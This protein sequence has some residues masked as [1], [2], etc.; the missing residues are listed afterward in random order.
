MTGNNLT[1]LAVCGD[2]FSVGHGLDPE[3]QF[4]K[5]FGGLIAEQLDLEHAVYGRS[6]CCNFVIYLQVKKI[7]EQH[8]KNPKFRPF[9]IVSSTWWCR[10]TFRAKKSWFGRNRE[11]DLSD[12]DYLNYEP[13]RKEY[14]VRRS[15]PFKPNRR[16]RFVSETLLTFLKG[17]EIRGLEH[18]FKKSSTENIS[19]LTAF[20]EEVYDEQL[21]KETDKCMLGSAHL[22]LKK[23]N[24]PHV[25]LLQ[26]ENDLIEHKNNLQL[27]WNNITYHYPDVRGTGHC[28]EQG[29]NIAANTILQH[30]DHYRLLEI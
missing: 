19:P 8:L 22:L 7:V 30:I 25:F 10:I 26:E 18:L 24:I 23:H 21:K 27:H 3:V 5:S 9:V 13:Y 1:H 14:P 15:L 16:F 2:S 20:F 29:H 28:N 12:V 11:P 4:E 17:Q 6:G